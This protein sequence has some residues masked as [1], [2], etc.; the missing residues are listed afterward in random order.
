MIPRPAI[1][2]ARRPA[3]H[4]APR[5]LTLIEL[6]AALA[7]FALVA[8]LG[9]QA[10]TGTLRLRDRLA[11]LAAETAA[12][13]PGLALLRRDLGGLVP[14]LFHPPAGGSASALALD[15]GGRVLALSVSGQPDLPAGRGLGLAR[16]EWRLD[17][18]RRQLLRRAWPALDPAPGSRPPPETVWLDGVT[19]WQVRSH[20]PDQS[21]REGVASLAPAAAPEPGDG[22]SFLTA[23]PDSYSGILPEAVEITLQFDG[24]GPVRIL[25][26]LR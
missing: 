19:G 9:L 10:L 6:V 17:P 26:T 22:D 24:L 3:A 14:M 5:G 15:A 7:V 23:L 4:P 25:E 16:V 20:W 11:L 1:R 21:W 8:T 18:A 13:A 12:L 2:P